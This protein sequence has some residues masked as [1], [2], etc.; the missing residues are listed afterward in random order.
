MLSFRS[1]SHERRI[2]WALVIALTIGSWLVANSHCAFGV[3]PAKIRDSVDSQ[4]PMHSH[5]KQAPERE[6]SGGCG[7]LPCCKKLQSIPTPVVQLAKPG[8]LPGLFDPTPETLPAS[9]VIRLARLSPILGT[10]PPGENSFAESVLQR[11]IL[12]HAP[13]L[14]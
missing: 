3:T 13:P 9:T 1:M 12:A 7:D 10:G 6:K 14:R 5:P 4:C 2:P 8:P 11:S